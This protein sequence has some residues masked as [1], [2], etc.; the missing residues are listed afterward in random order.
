MVERYCPELGL[1][2]ALVSWGI[3]LAGHLVSLTLSLFVKQKQPE[4]GSLGPH[5]PTLA[6]T[7]DHC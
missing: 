7:H 6:K 1:T 3:H 4:L 5:I 2:G